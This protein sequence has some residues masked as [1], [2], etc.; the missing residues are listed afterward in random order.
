MLHRHLDHQRIALAVI[1]D[2][3]SRGRWQVSATSA[4]HRFGPIGSRFEAGALPTAKQ[5]ANQFPEYAASNEP[6]TVSGP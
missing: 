5:P 3:I 1:D 6:A 2:I 4:F